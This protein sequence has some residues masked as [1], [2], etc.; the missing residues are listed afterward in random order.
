MFHAKRVLKLYPFVQ[1]PEAAFGDRAHVALAAALTEGTPLPAEFASYQWVVDRVFPALPVVRMAEVGFNFTAQWRSVGARDWQGKAWM[2]AADVLALTDDR[3]S[4]VVVDHKTGKSRYPDLD[5]LELMA[6]FTMLDNPSVDY[7]RGV[8][9]FLQDGHTAVR[10]FTRAQ[11]AVLRSKWDARALA[12]E[13]AAAENVWPR[14][15]SALCPWCPHKPCPNWTP[16]PE[17]RK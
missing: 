3:G 13:A 10:D 12:V 8:L 17:K 9:L 15:K 6:L 4:A 11:V 16:P 7:V 1:S 2:G 5:Q 14:K